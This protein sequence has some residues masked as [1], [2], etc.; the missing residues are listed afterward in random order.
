L[1]ARSSKAGQVESDNSLTMKGL[2]GLIYA[3]SANFDGTG[4]VINLL[5]KR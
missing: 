3:F 1:T 5:E 2:F 4:K